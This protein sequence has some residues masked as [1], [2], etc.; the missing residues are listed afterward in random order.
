MLAS[1]PPRRRDRSGVIPTTALA[2]VMF[3]WMFLLLVTS[4][5]TPDTN[6]LPAGRPLEVGAGVTIL[7]AAGWSWGSEAGLDESAGVEAIVIQK[8]GVRAFFI[9]EP[10]DG[11]TE[12][13]HRL[14]LDD[15]AQDLDMFEAL[16][17][18][19]VAMGVDQAGLRSAFRG[20]TQEN[21]LEGVLASLAYRGSGISC[22]AFGR[23]GEVAAVLPDLELML[24]T[25][26]LP[27]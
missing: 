20:W 11:P 22:L 25:L 15:L 16:L 5:L 18:V 7:P 6:L 17:P 14:S 9:V 2:A 27:R 23:S 10:F 24:Q 13:F 1:P 19:E 21:L 4:A 12:E 3:G 26:G 8:A